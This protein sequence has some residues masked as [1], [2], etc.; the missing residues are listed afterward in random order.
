M[1]YVCARGSYTRIVANTRFVCT[2]RLCYTINITRVRAHNCMGFPAVGS[3]GS[4]REYRKGEQR[5][6][7]RNERQM[8]KY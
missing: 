8:E 4:V 1:I 2:R 6:R 7:V 3:G 5:G